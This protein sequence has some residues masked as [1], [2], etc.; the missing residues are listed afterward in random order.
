MHG[1]PALVDLL[2][3]SR[4]EV[5]LD[6]GGTGHHPPTC[7]ST[8]VATFD[9]LGERCFVLEPADAGIERSDPAALRGGDAPTNAAI[10]RAVLAGERGPCRDSA[11]LNAAAAL[12]VAGRATNLREGMAEAAGAVDSGRAADVL[13]RAREI[14]GS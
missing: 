5:H 9:D 13:R 7:G 4:V 6:R 8:T 11:L 14:A 2:R 12:V 1:S 10:A 3:A